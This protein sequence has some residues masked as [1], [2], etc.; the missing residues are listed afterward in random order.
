MKQNESQKIAGFP[1]P[2][3]NRKMHLIINSEKDKVNN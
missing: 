1:Y 3:S 2:C